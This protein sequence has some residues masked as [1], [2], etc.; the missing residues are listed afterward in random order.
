MARALQ[1]VGS[2]YPLILLSN[3]SQSP[4][5]SP[6]A[7]ALQKLNCRL[8]PVSDVPLPS[9]LLHSFNPDFMQRWKFAW[10]KLQVWRLTEFEKLVWM[11]SDSIITRNVDWLFHQSG[12]W[13][14]RD[15]WDCT[16]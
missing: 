9:T 10:L 11:D 16:D 7:Q 14:Q 8:L 1:R 3:L 4:D 6:L 5:G 15:N 13:M 12:T 2:K